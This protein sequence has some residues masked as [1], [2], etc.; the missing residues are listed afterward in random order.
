ML[1]TLAAAGVPMRGASAVTG[2]A[3]SRQVALQRAA[4][5]GQCRRLTAWQLRQWHDRR[6]LAARQVA[7]QRAAGCAVPAVSQR[8]CRGSRR[9]GLPAAW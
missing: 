6:V 8:C 2:A 5:R 3:P 7:L 9:N 1:P 4:Q